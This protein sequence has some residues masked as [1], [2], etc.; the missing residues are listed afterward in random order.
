MPT[1]LEALKK[2]L[3]DQADLTPEL[4]PF[5]G[6]YMT[7]AAEEKVRSAAQHGGTVSALVRLALE[8]RMIDTAVLAEEQQAFL[9][10]A[11]TVRNPSEVLKG[12]KSKF[13]VSPTVAA[14]NEIAK[15]KAV[16]IGVVAT[17]CQALA[18]AKMRLKPFSET[19]TSI[20]KLKLVIGLF[21]GWA[22]SWR[23]LKKL[24]SERFQ[25]ESIQGLDIPPS[26]HQCMEVHTSKGIVEL[27]IEDILSS[28]R[29]SCK[30]CFDM[31]CEFCDISVGS[32]RSPE[33]WEVDRGW[34]QVIVRTLKG[35]ALLDLARSRG[36]LEFRDVPEENL[37]KLKRAS[38]NK[39]RTCVKNLIEKSG[40]PDDLLYL[41]SSDPVVCGLTGAYSG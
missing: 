24:L 1:D 13:V 30:Y 11:V 10:E 4:G 29:E 27:P 15:G 5:R 32:A 39:K 41:D 3:F 34:N 19:D 7:R 9:S 16:K 33:G 26:K 17:P 8:E 12:A 28:V 21:C 38:M 40:S 20:D 22:L 23:G 31:T 36:L 25:G 14:F 18:L 37:E 6:L 35:Q 2:R